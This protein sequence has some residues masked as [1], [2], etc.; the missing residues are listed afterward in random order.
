MS[1]KKFF[2]SDI[3]PACAYCSHGRSITGGKE[4]FCLK[5]GIVDANNSCR[6]FKYDVLKR[7]PQGTSIEKNYSEED[8]KL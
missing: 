6:A 4:V 5:K 1:N 3:P 7:K 2:K 8:F